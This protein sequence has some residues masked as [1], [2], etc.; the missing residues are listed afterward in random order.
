MK[1]TLGKKGKKRR[2]GELW[3]VKSDVVGIIM[4][5]QR[6]PTPNLQNCEC[7]MWQ[8]HLAGMVKVTDFGMGR[9]S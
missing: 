2:P 4:P 6:H 7:V 5:S 3:A 9:F 8:R 1:S